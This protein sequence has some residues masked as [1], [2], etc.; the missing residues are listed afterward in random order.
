M[1]NQARCGDELRSQ[2]KEVAQNVLR[3][4]RDAKNSTSDSPPPFS[5]GRG[6]YRTPD[7]AL[8]IGEKNNCETSRLL[9][10][11]TYCA[12]LIGLTASLRAKR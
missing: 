10:E 8:L 9:L 6:H 1:D 7:F 3:D 5:K 12:G 4:L 11:F 2:Y